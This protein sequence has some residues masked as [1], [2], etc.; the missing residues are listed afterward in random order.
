MARVKPNLSN[1]DAAIKTRYVRPFN[2]IEKAL[3][4]LQNLLLLF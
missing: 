1:V 4:A 3:P 2:G